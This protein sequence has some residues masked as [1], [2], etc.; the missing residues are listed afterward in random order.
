MVVREVL[1][2]VESVGYAESL[3]RSGMKNRKDARM[4]PTK[5]WILIP[6]TRRHPSTFDVESE[7]PS[8]TERQAHNE[9]VAALPNL[10][11]HPNKESGLVA[12]SDP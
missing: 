8:E 9:R 1:R 6:N 12:W 2:V 5:E 4:N 7:R 3:I 10:P 11:L